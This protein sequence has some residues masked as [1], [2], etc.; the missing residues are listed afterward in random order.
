MHSAISFPCK[1]HVRTKLFQEEKLSIKNIEFFLFY[2]DVKIDKMSLIRVSLLKEIKFKQLVTFFLSLITI[3][4][5][6]F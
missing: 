3:Y 4:L 1:L 6:P 5:T 2:S